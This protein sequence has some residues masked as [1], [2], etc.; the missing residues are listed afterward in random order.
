MNESR[1]DSSDRHGWIRILR[2]S[3]RTSFWTRC[4]DGRVI[5]TSHVLDIATEDSFAAVEIRA[6]LCDP[7]TEESTPDT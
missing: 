3:R 7:V 4:V 6:A 2:E 5:K 1:T